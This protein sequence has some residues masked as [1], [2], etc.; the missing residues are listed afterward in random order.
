MLRQSLPLRECGLKFTLPQASQHFI[1]S[2]PLRECGLKSQV[3][4]SKREFRES[5][6]LRECGLK[7]VS[8]TMSTALSS[9]S[10]C[11]SVD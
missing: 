10:P 4:D 3:R 2:L 9:H 7:S 6:P 11:G 8:Q 5:L 1:V